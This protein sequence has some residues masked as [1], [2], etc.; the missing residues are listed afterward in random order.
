MTKSSPSRVAKRS[1]KK[2][3]TS[4]KNG[5]VNG[6]NG[7]NGSGISLSESQQ[8][9]LRGI[10]STIMGKKIDLANATLRID[11][12]EKDKARILRE[13]RQDGETFDAA[14][15][16]IVQEHGIDPDGDERWRL[17]LKNMTLYRNA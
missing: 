6:A 12:A 14:T 7:A 16:E 15:R 1:A 2:K 13:I 4:K 11:K 5:A 17:E 10:E 8:K 9:Q 3:T